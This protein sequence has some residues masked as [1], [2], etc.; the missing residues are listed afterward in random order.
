[1]TATRSPCRRPHTRAG[2]FCRHRSGRSSRI[3]VK[4]IIIIVSFR[5]KIFQRKRGCPIWSKC[6]RGVTYLIDAQQFCCFLKLEFPA[7][8]TYADSFKYVHE[9]KTRGMKK[10]VIF[11]FAYSAKLC[12]R[13]RGS[14]LHSIVSCEP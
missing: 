1:M 14:W 9:C 4:K 10:Y 2:A 7:R 6:Y 12:L 8:S 11:Y 3:A 5:F 13:K